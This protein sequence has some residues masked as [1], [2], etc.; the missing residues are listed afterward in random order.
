MVRSTF[1]ARRPHSVTGEAPGQGQPTIWA[2]TFRN[3]AAI[4]TNRAVATAMEAKRI[5][6]GLL[7][8]I[9]F[10]DVAPTK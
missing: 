8:G 4:A 5:M 7:G 9:S 6:A 3:G 2:A 1:G 10:R